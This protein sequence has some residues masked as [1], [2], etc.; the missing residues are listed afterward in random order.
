M[1]ILHGARRPPEDYVLWRDPEDT[2]CSKAIRNL[3]EGGTSVAKKFSGGSP[4]QARADSRSGGYRAGLVMCHAVQRR[5]LITRSQESS[6]PVSAASGRGGPE[7][8]EL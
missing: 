3:L 2:P 6:I 4:L 8:L 7:S 5:H 1:D